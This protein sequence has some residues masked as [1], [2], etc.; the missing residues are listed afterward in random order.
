MGIYKYLGLVLRSFPTTLW[1][2]VFNDIGTVSRH[3]RQKIIQSTQS[4]DVQHVAEAVF[5]G[6]QQAH[7]IAYHVL[8]VY[9]SYQPRICG[10]SLHKQTHVTNLSYHCCNLSTM[11]QVDIEL[12][13]HNLRPIS[14]DF[15]S[16]WTIV[17]LV[18][19]NLQISSG[20]WRPF[21]VGLNVLTYIDRKQMLWLASY[22]KVICC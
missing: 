1:S 2:G 10:L 5:Y 14:T 22:R 8:G 11:C 21:C 6:V 3:V 13:V 9:C 4:N 20:K 17:F 19:I 7:I 16:N 12:I 18:K 15:K